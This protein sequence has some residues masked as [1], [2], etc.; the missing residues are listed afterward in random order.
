MK[1]L[2][3]RLSLVLGCSL[4][5]SF[6]TAQLSNVSFQQLDWYGPSG[7]LVQANS[8][9]GQVGFEYSPSLSPQ[10]LN[11]FVSNGSSSPVL[12]IENMPLIQDYEGGGSVSEAIHF[13][14]ASIGVSAGQD[15][16]SLQ[17][18]Y[19]VNSAP[20]TPVAPALFAT[21]VAASE[22][23]AWDQ[24]NEVPGTFTDPGSPAGM[25]GTLGQAINDILRARRMAS[26]QE[27][28]NHCFAGAT[29]RSLGWLN[30]QGNFNHNRTSQEIYD[31]LVT[32]GVSMPNADGTKAREKWIKKKNDYARS[33]SRNSIVTSVWD[34]G[35]IVDPVDGV[36]ESGGDFKTWLKD[37]MRQKKD[38]EIVYN[39][40]GG[41]HIVTVLGLYE[42]GGDCYALY[43][44]DE[45]Q[46][47]NTRGDGLMGSKIKRAKITKD[48]TSYRFGGNANTI[49]WAL[50]EAVPEP[51]SATALMVGALLFLRR[52]KA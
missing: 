43:A 12:A 36:T 7:S 28:V 37:A 48:G 45:K 15:V 13:D 2:S 40:P 16:S 42:Q 9:W 30:S 49:T 19:T 23:L 6:A 35:G 10:Y 47:D 8:L 20:V 46:G 32:A 17:F 34:S 26:V 21:S 50:S 52:K 14:L 5:G 51:S 25:L 38:V 18:G 22:R 3:F 29:A 33:M 31:D 41:G 11:L 39:F 4:C 27:A 44:D 24:L 1:H